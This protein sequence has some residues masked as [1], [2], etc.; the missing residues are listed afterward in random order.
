MEGKGLVSLRSCKASWYLPLAARLTYPWTSLWAGQL[1]LHG[2]V[3][4]FSAP[5]FPCAALHPLHF[6]LSCRTIPVFGSFVMAPS[7]HDTAQGGSTQCLQT[8]TRHMK[9]SLP[10]TTFGPSP[11]TDT[12]LTASAPF[13]S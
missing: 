12:Y 8:F 3:S 7:G 6:S 5:A 11:Q 1:T 2:E 9:S 10:S 13:G 4:C